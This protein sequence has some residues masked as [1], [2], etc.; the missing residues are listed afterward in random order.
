M[1]INMNLDICICFGKKITNKPLIK[2]ARLS[3]HGH[4]VMGPSLHIMKRK[5]TAILLTGAMLLSMAVALVSCKPGSIT[6][7]STT[8]IT[9]ETNEECLELLN[10]VFEDTLNQE[11]YVVTCKTGGELVYK[12]S[13][14]GTST[15]LEMNNTKT[16]A[17][18]NNEKYIVTGTDSI[19]SNKEVYDNYFGYF[20]SGIEM[21]EDFGENE[22]AFECT[23]HEETTTTYY[24]EDSGKEN[25]SVS[26]GT[27]NFKCMVHSDT[28]MEI[29]LEIVL[30]DNLIKT[31]TANSA[32][33]GKKSITTFEYGT[34][35]FKLPHVA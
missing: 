26:I 7:T 4:E 8:D 31:I 20:L 33:T 35:D 9:A 32:Q 12:Q 16:Y 18:I 21:F 23:Y 6:S 15:L 30:Q 10:S 27:L 25:E 34:A 1:V 17:F 19:E 3:S 28:P 14:I 5:I 29:T 24:P 13:F 22:A 11:N 2:E